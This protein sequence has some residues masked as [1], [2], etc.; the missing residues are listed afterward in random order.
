MDQEQHANKHHQQHANNKCGRQEQHAKEQGEYIK[1][2]QPK[3][4]IRV[5][6]D[7]GKHFCI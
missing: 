5:S 1:D 4:Y 3:N 7:L 2:M 6:C